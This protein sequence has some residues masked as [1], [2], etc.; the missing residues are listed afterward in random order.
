MKK[1]SPIGRIWELGQSEHGRLITA[2][3][4]AAAGSVF[5]MLPYFAA[6]KIIVQLLAGQTLLSAYLPWLAAALGGFLARTVLYNTALSLSHTATFSILK[7]I[8]QQ[9]M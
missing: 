1:Q 9:L 4:L 3:A 6:A 8:R 5:G 7:T 2:V